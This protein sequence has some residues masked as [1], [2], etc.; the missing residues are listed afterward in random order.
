[1]YIFHGL[2]EHCSRWAPVS[3]AFAQAGFRV[4]CID[5]PG[6]GRTTGSPRGHVGGWANVV[7]F[8]NAL[9]AFD[10]HVSSPKFLVSFEDN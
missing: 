4:H 7:K 5:F 8:G 1:M 10:R 2:G 6:H 3:I 9:L